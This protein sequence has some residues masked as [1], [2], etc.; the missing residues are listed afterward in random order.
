MSDSVTLPECEYCQQPAA[1][2]VCNGR[3]SR[4]L[5]DWLPGVIAEIQAENGAGDG[6]VCLGCR[7]MVACDPDGDLYCECRNRRRR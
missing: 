4:D 5:R 3:M 2:T 1:H 7:K 6:M